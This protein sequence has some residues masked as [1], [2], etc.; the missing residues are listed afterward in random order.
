MKR[1]FTIIA[2]ALGLVLPMQAQFTPI[3]EV[4]K[5]EKGV[6]R[7]MMR[8][9]PAAEITVNDI[10]GNYTGNAKSAFQG[11]P[12]ETWS[13]TITADENDANKV[14]I[15]PVCLF[16][17][18]PVDYLSPVYA[19]FN[20]AK[21]TLSMPLGQVVFEEPQYTFIIG[22]SEDGKK[23]DSTGTLELT[24]DGE[25]ILFP[26]IIFGL[27]DAKTDQWWYQAIYNVTYTKENN[28][29]FVYIYNKGS[30]QP[31]R[32]KASQLYFNEVEG[33]M[34]VTTTAQYN[35][36]GIAGTYYVYAETAF[37][38]YPDEEWNATI[39]IDETDA[40]KVWIHPFCTLSGLSSKDIKPVYA[41]YNAAAG[42]L[43]V[44]MG[45]VI[46]ETTN[47]RLILGSTSNGQTVNTTEPVVAYVA[48]G[49]IYFQGAAI[50]VGEAIANQWW[51]QAYY[52]ITMTAEKSQAF[53]LANIDRITREKPANI[54]NFTFLKPGNY[55]W[56]FGVPVSETELQ[57]Y[58]TTTTFTAGESFDLE[59]IFG[60]YATG[61]TAINW[62]IDGFLSEMGIYEGGEAYSIPA[63]SYAMDYMGQT[64]EILDILDVEKYYSSIGEI[65]LYDENDNPIMVDIKIGDLSAEMVDFPEFVA[66]S[67]NEIEYVGEQ[68]VLFYTEGELAYIYA[69]LYDVTITPGATAGAP[70]R[71]KAT[72]GEKATVYGQGTP[73][74]MSK[75]AFQMK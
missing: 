52:S 64:I 39:T 10:V 57:N 17:D 6:E 42:T 44:P 45:Q 47:T 11:S 66:Y 4:T 59:D 25:Y 20:A 62:S 67:E 2:I 71:I 1:I 48:D 37:D 9:A 23:V 50:G 22:A 30:E 41:T 63:I 56:S 74:K 55:T 24:I 13:L 26:D 35:A 54:G 65:L 46:F 29:P 34:C 68:L 12:D 8:K 27:G 43:S 73:V 14:W 16:G 60:E 15:Y 53:P 58:T 72:M 3:K 28:T 51:Y 33:E 7:K 21:G 32:L 19:T 31:S 40:S 49:V 5:S 75:K 61:L 18:V 36:E 38:G 69:A 70:M